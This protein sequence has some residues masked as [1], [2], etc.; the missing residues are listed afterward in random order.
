LAVAPPD[1]GPTPE[2]RG[3]SIESILDDWFHLQKTVEGILKLNKTEILLRLRF[4]HERLLRRTT[5]GAARS[6]GAYDA[7][8]DRVELLLPQKN[9][10]NPIDNILYCSLYRLSFQ[11]ISNYISSTL[12]NYSSYG[13]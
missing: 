3:P 8:A 4:L 10:T 12:M 5:F 11:L 9:E 1:E 7:G 13:S 2:Y 6:R